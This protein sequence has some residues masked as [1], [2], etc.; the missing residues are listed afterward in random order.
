MKDIYPCGGQYRDARFTV[1]IPDSGHEPPPASAVSI[2]VEELLDVLNDT[3][4]Q[5]HYRAAFALW[6]FNWIHPFPGGN[7]RTARALTYLVLC[8][9][10]GSMLP[11]VPTM[12]SIIAES[13]DEYLDALRS[14]DRKARGTSNTTE[15]AFSVPIFRQMVLFVTKAAMKQLVTSLPG[16]RA[17]GRVVRVAARFI[18]LVRNFRDHH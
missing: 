10:F 7:G 16:Q 13:R 3:D 1:R 4:K 18:A 2:Y 11:G 9:D 14:A 6:R 15:A 12:P 5:V 17:V 8:I